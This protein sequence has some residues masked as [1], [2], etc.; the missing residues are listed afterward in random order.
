MGTDKQLHRYSTHTYTYKGVHRDTDNNMDIVTNTYMNP[1]RNM[2]GHRHTQ[3]WIHTQIHMDISTNTSMNKDKA[4]SM[5][6]DTDIRIDSEKEIS[7]DT[8]TDTKMQ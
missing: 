8:D 4:K 7:M 3:A 5:Y 6:T 2:Y 1:N